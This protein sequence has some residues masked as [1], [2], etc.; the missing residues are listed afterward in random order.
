[1]NAKAFENVNE[2]HLSLKSRLSVERSKFGK[3]GQKKIGI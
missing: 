3:N 2:K 1:V